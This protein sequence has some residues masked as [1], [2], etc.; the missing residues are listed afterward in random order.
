M[1]ELLKRKPKDYTNE[2]NKAIQ[3]ED[4]QKHSIRKRQATKK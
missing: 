4:K 1:K 3:E 2:Y